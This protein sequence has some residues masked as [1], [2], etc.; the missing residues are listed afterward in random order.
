MIYE[1]WFVQFDFPNEEGKPYK[2]SGGEMVYDKTLKRDIPK[3]WKSINIGLYIDDPE[4]GKRPQGGIN[5]ELRNGIPS[6]GAE[7]IDELGKFDFYSTPYIPEE[8]KITSG[9]IKDNDILIYKDGAYVGKTTL[10]RNG[11]PFKYATVNEHV[12]LIRSVDHIAQEYLF[13]TLKQK[14][15]FD[16][17]QRLGKAK[18]A[19]P[20]LNKDD[21]NGI[22][23]ISPNITTLKVFHDFVDKILD[24]LFSSANEIRDLQ[25]LR[26]FLLPILMNGQI[27]VG[28]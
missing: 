4:S 27:S 26:D 2:S 25:K 23:I 13:F 12:F 14:Q 22:Y 18:A 5:K 11:F 10:F 9:I 17:M 7:C 6:L 20:G 3:G 19:Q 24:R 8:T 15:Y 28:E 16:I 1:H 21:L